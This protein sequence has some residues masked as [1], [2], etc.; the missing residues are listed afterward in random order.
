M[1]YPENFEI[2]IGFDR[3]RKLLSEKCL[4][5]MGMEQAESIRF[6]D[7]HDVLV[8]NLSATYEFQQLLQFE[9]FFP[10]DNYFRISHSL[11]KI[12]IEGTFPEVQEVFDMKRSLETVKA[13]LGFFRS[14]EAVR[15]PVLRE[16]A[17]SVR[18][19]PY[20]LE[21]I[22][23]IIDRKGIIKDNASARLKEI[24]AELISKNIHVSKRLAAILKQAQAD[25]S[26]NEGYKIGNATPA[27]QPK[28]QHAGQK[29]G[30]CDS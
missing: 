15:Y 7:D 8:H 23:R 18:M 4:S 12:R 5:P 14:K 13:I 17:S 1:I 29:R 9:D 21:A 26:E 20:V 28:H 6:T 22:D 3:I 30:S 19:Y 25:G 10:S 24:R 2:K 11:N 27:Y 16:R